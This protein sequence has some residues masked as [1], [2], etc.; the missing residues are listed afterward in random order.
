M[1]HVGT[2]AHVIMPVGPVKQGL[3]MKCSLLHCIV[4][5]HWCVS[6]TLADSLHVHCIL[7]EWRFQICPKR[8]LNQ[9]TAGQN[10]SLAL[11]SICVQ[12]AGNECEWMLMPQL[13]SI[14][15][16]WF[17]AAVIAT[18][19]LLPPP[20]APTLTPPTLPPTWL[21]A[22]VSAGVDSNI[23]NIYLK[24]SRLHFCLL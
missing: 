16:I 19:I 21:S 2:G 12:D 10:A 11:A 14:H 15:I 5:L 17:C 7:R 22:Q 9:G 24:W 18:V 1:G 13:G 8:Q 23:S 6:V 3:C 4:T 20:P